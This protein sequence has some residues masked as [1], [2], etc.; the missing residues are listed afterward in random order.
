MTIGIVT[1][2]KG[3]LAFLRQSLPAMMA[4]G[5]SVTV[6]DYGCPDGTAAWVRENFSSA[7]VVAVSD[8][9]FFNHAEARNLGAQSSP[10]EALAFIDCDIL[11]G[12]AFAEFVK[13]NAIGENVFLVGETG[14]DGAIVGE[15]VVPRRKLQEIGG[16]D[17]VITGWGFEDF[18]LYLRLEMT[19]AQRQFMPRH[20]FSPVTH[21][22]DLR[23]AYTEQKNRW[24]SHRLNR[25]YSRIK[26]DLE[27]HFRRSL[28]VSERKQVRQSAEDAVN[29][30]RSEP[31]DKALS[32]SI[33][34]GR[35]NFVTPT[36]N[37]QDGAYTLEGLLSYRLRL[38]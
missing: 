21:S 13:A 38:S 11:V 35:D 10:G 20:L 24:E 6:V 30:L 28:T 34:L 18:D 27:T 5:F 37:P 14:T 19:G 2:C 22:D 12:D 9:P 33:P 23:T 1:T 26:L 25:I 31:S 4:T 17:E 36:Q 3:R 8:R 15:C 32:F 16:Y 29:K 7:N